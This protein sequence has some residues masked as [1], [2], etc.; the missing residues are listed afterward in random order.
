[1]QDALQ[2]SDGPVVG[3]TDVGTDEVGA[4]EVGAN[5]VGATVGSAVGAGAKEKRLSHAFSSVMSALANPRVNSEG[6][7]RRTIWL[8]CSSISIIA[9]QYKVLDAICMLGE[10]VKWC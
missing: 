1:M 8:S 7:V 6:I 10:S 3:A 5:E 9:A 2:F 4:K